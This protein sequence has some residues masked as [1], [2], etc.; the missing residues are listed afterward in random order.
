MGCFCDMPG[1]PTAFTTP[2]VSAGI[3]ADPCNRSLA[4]LPVCSG[5]R[6]VRHIGRSAPEFLTELHR[7]SLRPPSWPASNGGGIAGCVI[8]TPWS[9]RSTRPSPLTPKEA[10]RPRRG[11]LR[12]RARVLA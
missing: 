9:T 1:S 10:N 4:A 11:A 8:S 12:A 6:L 2:R 5:D 3:R 7:S